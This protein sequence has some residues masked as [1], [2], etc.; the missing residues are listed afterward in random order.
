MQ[1]PNLS[2]RGRT[3]RRVALAFVLWAAPAGAQQQD[4]ASL[5]R[6]SQIVFQ[7]TIQK[8]GAA[9]EPSLP[10]DDRTSVV[11]VDQVLRAP[12]RFPPLKGREVTVQLRRDLPATSGE[13]GVFF[14][15]A[16]SYGKTL[17]VLE[18]GRMDVRYASA[19]PGQIREAERAVAD[20]KLAQ[21]VA[22]AQLIVLGQV[23]GTR[24]AP[25]DR[26]SPVTEHDPV[27]W[28][29]TIA[30][31]SVEKGEKPASLRVLFPASTDEMW[32]DAPKLRRG[33]NALFLLQRDQQE[34][35]M[36]LLRRPGWTALDP[37]DV[38][39][40]DQVGRVR[41]LLKKAPY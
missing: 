15:R 24:P 7:G 6:Q 10:V 32:I 1:M 3:F 23:T 39:P 2:E 38:L 41:Q 18:V 26:K 8:V 33:M 30:V 13:S 28:E 29:A 27:W 12:D 17:A 9:T 11:R 21:R 36:P 16:W 20:E 31:R 14:T 19:L 37:L 35:G 25:R 22:K 5:V 4:L 40:P 34:K